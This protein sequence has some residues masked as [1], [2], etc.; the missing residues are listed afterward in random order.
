M[1]RH[2]S[3]SAVK[4]GPKAGPSRESK[5][6]IMQVSFEIPAPT[7]LQYVAEK[8]A[9]QQFAPP[10]PRRAVWSHSAAGGRPPRSGAGER[11]AAPGISQRTPRRA[12]P[13]RCA[14]VAA[15]APKPERYKVTRPPSV[16]RLFPKRAGSARRR[17]AAAA[18][19][20]TGRR[21][22]IKAP[23]PPKTPHPKTIPTHAERRS[24]S[25]RSRARP[26]RS[27]SSRATR[28]TT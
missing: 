24:S 22:F 10:L 4:R 18:N 6:A 3:A 14:G 17:R 11:P 7:A 1:L 9:E 28:S 8:T 5:A 23:P 12:A 20:H 19:A 16:R 21:E 26:S 27:M 13:L 15:A 25:R 2:P